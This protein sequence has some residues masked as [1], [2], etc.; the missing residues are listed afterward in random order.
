MATKLINPKIRNT[1]T[2]EAKAFV[3]AWVERRLQ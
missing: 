3:P 1:E 2:V